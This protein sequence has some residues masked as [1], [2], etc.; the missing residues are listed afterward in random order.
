MSDKWRSTSRRIAVSFVAMN[1]MMSTVD[2]SAQCRSSRKRTQ[3]DVGR[4]LVKKRRQLAFHALLR[5]GRR[6]GQHAF[7]RRVERYRE[8]HVP[9]RR[10]RLH[11]A[12][13]R[14]LAAYE[15]VERF[16]KRQ[17]R[18]GAGEAFRAAPAG[19]QAG[20][21]LRL[22]LRPGSPRPTWSCRGRLRPSRRAPDRAPR[23]PTER[24]C[25]VVRARWTAR[26]SSARPAL[27]M[28]S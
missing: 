13:D 10:H 3:R 1:E 20:W 6:F 4:D 12:P 21:V 2:V 11:H 16:E 9:G 27:W 7:N 18:L 25:A 8:L 19:D 28:T 23:W 14:R 5:D 17:V 15:A 22:K 26:R 24:R